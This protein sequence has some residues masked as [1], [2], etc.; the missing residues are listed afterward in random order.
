MFVLSALG[1]S[2]PHDCYYCDEPFWNEP[3]TLEFWDT[4]K[5]CSDACSENEIERAFEAQQEYY[6]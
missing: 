4:R 2:A 6:R 5:F 1:A 3:V